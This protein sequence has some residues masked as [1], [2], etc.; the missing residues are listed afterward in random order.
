LPEKPIEQLPG[1]PGGGDRGSGQPT[2]LD[3]VVRPSPSH[4]NRP[5]KATCPQWAR[6]LPSARPRFSIS[7]TL[8]DPN[9]H[10]EDWL[11]PLSRR[12]RAQDGDNAGWHDSR[13]PR[14]T[15]LTR[16]EG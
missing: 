5:S 9:R 2:E 6:N 12:A 16:D 13:P 3:L 15:L 4:S 10:P 7:R 11:S 8:A 14:T 1:P